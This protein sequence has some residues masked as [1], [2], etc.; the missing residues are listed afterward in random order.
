MDFF[1][2]TGPE[3]LDFYWKA[4][5]VVALAAGLLPYL[6]RGPFDLPSYIRAAAHT[7][8]PFDIAYLNVF[9]KHNSC[10]IGADSSGSHQLEQ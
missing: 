6:F 9:H 1:K 3:F 8:D 10:S 7:L 2:L 4:F 5:V